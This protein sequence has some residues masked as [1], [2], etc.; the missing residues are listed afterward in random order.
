MSGYFK[1]KQ[2]HRPRKGSYFICETCGDEFY[3]CPSFIRQHEKHGSKIR[4]CSMKCYDKTGDKNPFHGK[5]HTT[6]SKNKMS[7]NPN[8]PKFQRGENNPNFLRYGSESSYIGKT[9]VWWRK[10]L[11]KEIGECEK[12]GLKDKRILTI[13]HKDRNKENNT[14]ENLILL[15]W[16][17]HNLDHY[18]SK[19]GAYHNCKHRD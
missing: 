2:G 7:E 11:L 17:C 8:R 3:L 6:E 18:K 14:R 4:F 12:C 13:H 16:N 15:C 5:K 10:K 19:T 9:D 1:S